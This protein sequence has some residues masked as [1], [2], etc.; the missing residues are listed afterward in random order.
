[1]IIGHARQLK[2]LR[3]L[4]SNNLLPSALLFG[5]PGGVGKFEIAKELASTLL[6]EQPKAGERCK[7]CRS[8]KLADSG[9]H[10]DL[11]VLDA[12]NREEAST[13]R[14]RELLHSL[15]LRSFQGGARIV[16]ARSAEHMVLQAANAL[17]KSLEEPRP[18]NYFILVSDSPDR[19]PA[20]VRSRCQQW[21]FGPLMQ[22]ELI[23][24]LAKAKVNLPAELIAL[25]DGSL[26]RAQRIEAAGAEISEL[27][28]NLKK[29]L[30]GDANTAIVTAQQ[31][32]SDRDSIRQNLEHCT[33]IARAMLRQD[34]SNDQFARVAVFLHNIIEAEPLIV[35]RHLNAA[36][37]LAYT[38]ATL[39]PTSISNLHHTLTHSQPLL[40]AL[41]AS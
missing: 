28:G 7:S 38:F 41:T 17:L 14:T 23:R 35:E 2:A 6:C 36:A 32:A 1:M 19:L 37:L 5:G 26:A 13:E 4:L 34:L 40:S 31:I 22:E 20:T 8:C 27:S 3:K 15:G 16:I 9:N 10:P 25:S 18:G 12:S 21:N 33:T 29:I 24:V 39:L 30:A 11:I